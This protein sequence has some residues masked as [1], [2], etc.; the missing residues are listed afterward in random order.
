MRLRKTFMG[1]KLLN[2]CSHK[3][4][5]APGHSSSPRQKMTARWKKKSQESRKRLAELQV[6]KDVRP[7]EPGWMLG[8]QP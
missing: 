2:E 3:I 1:V 7:L 6:W 8:S 4:N 5:R